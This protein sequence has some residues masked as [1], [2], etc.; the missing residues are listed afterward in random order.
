MGLTS[1][2]LYYSKVV[3][4]DKQGN[5]SQSA[6]V[7]TTTDGVHNSDIAP[8]LSQSFRVEC[9][10]AIT[11]PAGGSGSQILKYQNTVWQSGS[12]SYSL[13]TGLFTAGS[14]VEVS[15]SS[16]AAPN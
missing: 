4:V 14:V 10:A 3:I 13:T 12:G 7:A 5:Q 2:T 16:R 1:N 6:Q 8:D 15:F 9:N 11:L